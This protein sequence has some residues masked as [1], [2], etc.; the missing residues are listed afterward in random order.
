MWED[1]FWKGIALSF[2]TL[3]GVLI[4]AYISKAGR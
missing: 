4:G 3:L 1:P 2:L